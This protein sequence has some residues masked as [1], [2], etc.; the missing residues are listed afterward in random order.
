VRQVPHIAGMTDELIN[1][2]LLT[3]T[4]VEGTWMDPNYM[5]AFWEAQRVGLWF[6]QHELYW[7]EQARIE[8]LLRGAK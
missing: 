1:D 5:L 7:D 2:P 8:K 4:N 6:W 3:E